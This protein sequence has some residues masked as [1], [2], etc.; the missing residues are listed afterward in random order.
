MAASCQEHL[1]RLL[2]LLA[3]AI[4]LAYGQG[5][6]FGGYNPPAPI[7]PAFSCPSGQKAVGKPDH[8][9]W[10]Y[11]CK[12]AGMNILS[13]ANFDASNPFAGMQGGKSV[14]KCCIERDICKQTCGMT[15]KECH[16]TFQKCSAKICK[17]DQNCN[18]QAMMSEIMSEPV[19][20][21]SDKDKD[22]KYDPDEYKC[23]G[24]NRGQKEACMCVPKKEFKA[25][26]ENNLK[27]FY[28]KFNPE[29][30]NKKGEIKD[31]EEVWKKWKGKEP[32]M[33][34][35]LATKYKDKAV[36]IRVKPKP[37]PY[38]P[39]AYD[40]R[41]DASKSDE[42]GATADDASE[43]PDTTQEPEAPAPSSGSDVDAEDEEFDK[44]VKGKEEAKQK[45]KQDED[46]D[47]AEQV[48]EEIGQ[49]TQE[50]LKRLKDKKVKAIEEEDYMEAKRIKKRIQKLEL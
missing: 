38:T 26:T 27:S 19:D 33:L 20:T 37:P 35:A 34:M 25:A 13:A 16:E 22:K 47:L 15:S 11:G 46:Y 2:L 48:K 10:S 40:A 29:K 28:S 50:E 1:R 9:I 41:E 6:G 43:A 30:L 5:G 3:G 32:A 23:K 21:E 44:K 24:Y 14:N 49:M 12:D 18:L 42:T 31:V 39:P 36:E 17:G 7:C 4:T 45:A 8:K